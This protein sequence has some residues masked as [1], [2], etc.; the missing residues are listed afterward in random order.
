MDSTY[1]EGG[2]PPVQDFRPIALLEVLRKLWLGITV[3]RL[4]RL[5]TA[6]GDGRL[7]GSQYGFMRGR[8]TE[9]AVLEVLN[10][11]ESAKYWRSDLCLSS[12]DIRRAFDRIPKAMLI[13]AWVRMGV[14]ECIARY[15]VELDIQGS[16]CM[17]TPLAQRMFDR[18]GHQGLAT[19]ACLAELGCSQGDK[20]SPLNSNAFF[21]I[22]LTALAEDVK[23]M[24]T[25][26]DH[27]GYNRR[28]GDIAF[29]DDLISTVTSLQMLQRRADLV[30]AFVFR[31][32]IAV[33]KLRAF[34][35][36]WGNEDSR[37]TGMVGAYLSRCR[38]CYMICK[39]C[40]GHTAVVPLPEG[41]P[42][43]GVG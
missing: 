14:P 7:N 26:Q 5:W 40:E 36:Y 33:G 3:N 34:H 23:D 19:L 29:A 9:E 21:D 8:S 17:R 28:I 25:V 39:L 13:L 20:P 27:W 18:F 15:I 1:T 10:V 4:Q 12:W 35:V 24:F 22:L 38:Q 31:N 16:S 11:L 42:R 30:S 6:S 32:Y 2:Q 43:D 37:G 41:E